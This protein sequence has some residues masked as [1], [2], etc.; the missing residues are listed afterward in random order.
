M[1]GSERKRDSSGCTY[2]DAGGEIGYGRLEK[3]CF[4]PPVALIRP[5]RKRSS[6]LLSAG[7]AGKETLRKYSSGKGDR[8]RG[9]VVEVYR[10]VEPV[11]AVRIND[12]LGKCVYNYNNSSL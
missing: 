11:M 6:I 10:D 9:C 4:S 3:F 2:R 1:Q 12:I 7:D 5:H 8:L